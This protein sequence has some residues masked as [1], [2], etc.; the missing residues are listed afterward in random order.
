MEIDTSYLISEVFDAALAPGPGNLWHPCRMG[1][2]DPEWCPRC[3]PMP[4][5]RCQ[6][7]HPLLKRP[8]RVLGPHKVHADGSGDFWQPAAACSDVYAVF[9]SSGEC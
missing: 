7:L 5:E 1:Y 3:T 4:H 2:P 8:C 9:S 6:E